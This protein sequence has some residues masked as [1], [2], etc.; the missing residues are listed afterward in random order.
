LPALVGCDL[1]G[2]AETSNPDGDVGFSD[3]FGGDVRRWE[4]LRP[5]GVSVDGSGT[6]L[7]ARRNMQRPHQVDMHTRETC[8]REV[9]TPERS[10]ACTY[11]CACAICV[12]QF[13][14]IPPHRVASLPN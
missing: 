3:C 9:V 2:T 10:V 11:N 7:E 4:C 13:V 14:P 6:V 12:W 8:R 1:L 5:M